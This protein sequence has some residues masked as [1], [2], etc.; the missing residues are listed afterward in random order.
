M[1][2][3]YWYIS[4]QKIE[5]LKADRTSDRTS[6]LKEGALKLKSPFVEAGVTIQP[7]HSFFHDV[8]RIG[9][10]LLADIN[11]HTFPDL[12][13]NRAIP[14]FSFSGHAHR[15]VDHGAYWVITYEKASALLLAGALSNA[16]GA[17]SKDTGQISASIDPIGAIRQAFGESDGAAD[18]ANKDVGA[19]C[20]YVWQAIAGPVSDA[21][22]ALPRVEGIAAYGGAFPCAEEQFRRAGFPGIE[23]IVIGSP[24]YVRQI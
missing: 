5:V 23:T 15:A 6:W 2:G 14:F 10:S 8:E 1:S 11:T 21:W 19:K 7:E 18:A 17:P 16:I 3:I 20:S 24:I 4:R 22:D 12:P 13:P 9:N